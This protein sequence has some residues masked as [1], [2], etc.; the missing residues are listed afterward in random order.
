MGLCETPLNTLM[1][2]FPGD[3][4]TPYPKTPTSPVLKSLYF[5]NCVPSNISVKPIFGAIPKLL[6]G[7]VKTCQKVC[8]PAEGVTKLVCGV[9]KLKLKGIVHPPALMVGSNPKRNRFQGR[10]GL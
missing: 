2:N 9:V 5:K 7:L 8:L 1:R 3:K 6:A 4:F 10:R